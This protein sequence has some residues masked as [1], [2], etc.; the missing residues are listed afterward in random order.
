MIQLAVICEI[1]SSLKSGKNVK[2]YTTSKYFWLR[3]T[4]YEDESLIRASIK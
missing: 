2:D 1:K 3:R 4:F